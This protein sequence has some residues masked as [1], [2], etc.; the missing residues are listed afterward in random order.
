MSPYVPLR[1]RSSSSFSMFVSMLA[2]RSAFASRLRSRFSTFL[3]TPTSFGRA[4]KESLRMRIRYCVILVRRC[5]HL[6]TMK[7]GQYLSSSSICLSAVA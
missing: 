3:C 5:L 7:F 2:A 4:C 1:R 6:C